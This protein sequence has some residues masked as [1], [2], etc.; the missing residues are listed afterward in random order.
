[1]L[2][3]E[4]GRSR[5]EVEQEKESNVLMIQQL[6]FVVLYVK[7]LASLSQASVSFLKPVLLFIEPV[8]KR[9]TPNNCHQ[10]GNS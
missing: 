8:L 4:K 7:E 1:M 9:H 2:E 5:R 3:C 10:G 6:C